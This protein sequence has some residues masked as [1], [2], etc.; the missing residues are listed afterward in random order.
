V[1][2]FRLVPESIPAT[3]CNAVKQWL[4]RVR[5]APKLPLIETEKDNVTAKLDSGDGR[6]IRSQTLTKHLQEIR[7]GVLAE[8]Q[9]NLT[10][11]TE[12]IIYL[13]YRFDHQQCVEPL[14]VGIAQ[15]AGKKKPLSALF[16]SGW[17]RFADTFRSGGHI[18]KLNDCMFDGKSDYKHWCDALFKSTS[19]PKLHSPV[20]VDVQAR[21]EKSQSVSLRLGNTP[22]F[23][24]DTIRIWFLHLSGHAKTLLNREGNR[25]RS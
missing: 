15:T 11:S 3:A 2:D 1:T 20:F 9:E 8:A 17:L 23:V 25:R 4:K 14:Y 21:T 18:G 22:L 5:E 24:E 7:D 6:I 16:S 10:L 19:P 12:G 13:I